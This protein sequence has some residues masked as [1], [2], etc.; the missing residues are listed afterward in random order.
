M[1]SGI[2]C[3]VFIY[4]EGDGI[5]GGFIVFGEIFDLLVFIVV[6]KIFLFGLIICVMNVSN[7]CIVIVCINDCGFYVGGWCFDFL[8]VVMNVI[9]FG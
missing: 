5:V 9:V 6:L 1:I 4:G 8:M 2:I 3:L 7:G